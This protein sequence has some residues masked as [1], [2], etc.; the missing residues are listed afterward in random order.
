M[1]ALRN[2]RATT[3]AASVV[4]AHDH[5]AQ[6]VPAGQDVRGLRFRG[7]WRSPTTSRQWST[8]CLPDWTQLELDMRIFDEDRYVEAATLLTQI[9]A[10]P[11]SEHDWHWRLR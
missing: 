6:P 8:R 11:Y 5:R 7:P 3:L 4:A 9:N 2:A 1:G 10:M